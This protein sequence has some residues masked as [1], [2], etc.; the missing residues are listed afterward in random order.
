MINDGSKKYCPTAT[1]DGSFPGQTLMACTFNGDAAP[2]SV[3]GSV[4]LWR[5]YGRR[6]GVEGKV[7]RG[8]GFGRGENDLRTVGV[9]AFGGRKDRRGGH[10]ERALPRTISILDD[11]T[12]L[13]DWSV[14]RR[15]DPS[16]DRMAGSLRPGVEIGK[17]GLG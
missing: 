15:I 14:A 6:L 9:G 17:L 3:M 10:R 8:I 2:V 1:A 16:V 7:D 4:V 12:S 13:V 5:I 11:I